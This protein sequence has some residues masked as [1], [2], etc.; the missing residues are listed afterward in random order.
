M[1]N[2]TLLG[3]VLN[4][5]EPTPQY[6]G[7]R[8]PSKLLDFI[9]LSNLPGREEMLSKPLATM[10]QRSLSLRLPITLPDLVCSSDCMVWID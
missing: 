9:S 5:R 1:D 8:D 4:V 3:L 7:A 10:S 2:L 6:F